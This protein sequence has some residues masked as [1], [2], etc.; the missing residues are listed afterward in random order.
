MKSLKNLYTNK[1]TNCLFCNSIKDTR[2][3][4]LNCYRHDITEI[5]L[6]VALNS[7]SLNNHILT[8]I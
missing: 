3:V 8:F 2:D 6:K 1:K 7:I 4:L 5:L